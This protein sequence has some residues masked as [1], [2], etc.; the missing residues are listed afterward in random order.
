MNNVNSHDN[1]N[2]QHL[3]YRSDLD[4]LRAIAVLA[5]V[6]YHAFPSLIHGGFIGVDVFFVLSGFLISSIILRNLDAG[7]FSFTEFYSRRIKRIFPALITVLFT[8]LILGKYLL[9]ID[10]YAQLGKHVAAASVFL[11][12]F[13]LWHEAGYFD[14]T[15]ETKLLLN[16]WSLGIEEQFYIF[17]PLLLWL[18]YRKH[19]NLI[20]LT[21]L[22]AFI[23]FFWCLK[24]IAYDPAATFYSPLTRFWEL[25]SGAGIA[26][27][28]INPSKFLINIKLKLDCYLSSLLFREKPKSDGRVL[29][30]ALS[31]TGLLLF[32][33]G[34]WTLNNASVFPGKFALIPVLSSILIILAG[35][36]AYFN[37]ILLSNRI[38]V[39]FGL[40]SYPLYLWHW[41]LL[42]FARIVEGVTPN[43]LIRV[44]AVVIS[45]I[46][47]WL[48]YRFIERPL[49]SS[50]R[51]LT[52]LF[53]IC[54]MFFLGFIGFSIYKIKKT[55]VEQGSS[56]GSYINNCRK[57]INDP[58]LISG[59]L[60]QK[61]EGNTIALI[62]DSHA[63]HLFSGLIK[64]TTPDDGV[65]LFN[66]NCAAPFIDISTG[67][68]SDFRVRENAYKEINK[69]LEYV[70]AH[71]SINTVLLAH[72]PECSY[73]DAVD[74]QNITN[75]DY[76]VVLADGMRRTLKFLSDKGKRIIIILDNPI[77][78]I[79]PKKC[80]E[81]PFRFTKNTK[82]CYF[83]RQIFDSNIPVLEYRKIVN[84]VLKDFPNVI[85]VDLSKV[86]CDQSNCYLA[87][88][89]KLL[90]EDG[91]HLNSNGSEL[92]SPLLNQSIKQ[93]RDSSD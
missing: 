40:V 92:V 87:K 13:L 17:W 79:D 72:H 76:K 37:K 91:S 57:T 32:V 77:L 18:A 29:S 45:L 33:Y 83:S 63:G 54:T 15:A 26:Y 58:L 50:R 86:L 22:L 4:G 43:F 49:R 89:G 51:N 28:I 55:H 59:C 65:A 84:E 44:F 2:Y 93:V 78:P 39:W 62:G 3:K 23:S 48:T 36:L 64:N 25:L 8:C 11:S 82:Q 42:T 61:E 88:N 38:L 80:I 30:N 24:E 9:L 1:K 19:F 20:S 66:F 41:P 7:T 74:H 68:S 70:G 90:Y 16:L 71:Q 47:A 81:R 35:P 56:I 53:L 10:E 5:V 31:F 73:K 85:V 46:L 14:I 6:T 75:K 69:S 60:F 67:L 12:N 27:L 52:V 34:V 21:F